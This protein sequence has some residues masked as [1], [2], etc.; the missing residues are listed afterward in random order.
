MARP[1]GR[2]SLDVFK[3]LKEVSQA[4]KGLPTGG[5]PSGLKPSGGPSSV[6]RQVN[7]RPGGA[8]PNIVK[9]PLKPT[10]S[11]A[12]SNG[13]TSMFRPSELSTL[14]QNGQTAIK[15]ESE[16]A[17]SALGIMKSKAAM[18][19]N[20]SKGGASVIILLTGLGFSAATAQAYLDLTAGPDGETNL[21]DI[22]DGLERTV[23]DTVYMGETN[24]YELAKPD[25]KEHSYRTTLDKISQLSGR[26]AQA[27]GLDDLIA[28]IEL[29]NKEHIRNGHTG[30]VFNTQNLKV[31]SFVVRAFGKLGIDTDGKA[32]ACILYAASRFMSADALQDDA[33]SF[34]I[35]ETAIAKLTNAELLTSEGVNWRE[36]AGLTMVHLFTGFGNPKFRALAMC[37]MHE[38][39]EKVR[40][41][42]SEA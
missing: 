19:Q 7:P 25:S 32:S 26:E 14:M 22:A 42:E 39:M 31:L 33:N 6:S 29:D 34:Q 15:V 17:R 20:A 9:T 24:H 30:N 27:N 8:G 38:A 41:D 37:L 35:I 12:S 36:T 10:P 11:P 3:V 4:R 1:L 5:P 18:P 40:G 16:A 23:A 28:T 2:R 21:K 13:W